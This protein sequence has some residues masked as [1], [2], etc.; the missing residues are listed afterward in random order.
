MGRWAQAARRGGVGPDKTGLA[1]AAPGSGQFSV[2]SGVA[3][4]IAVQGIGSFPTGVTQWNAGRRLT[5]VGGA[6]TAGSPNGS[7]TA[8]I[9]L[10]GCTSGLQYDVV[11]WWADPAGVQMSAVSS[12]KTQVCL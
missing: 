4:H 7:P 3:T 2:T 1:P 12:I 8:V 10:S 9:D 5:S 6:Y 11:T